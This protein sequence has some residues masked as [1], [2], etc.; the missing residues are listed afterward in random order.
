MSDPRTAMK[1]PHFVDPRKMANQGAHLQGDIPFA[2]LPRLA[3]AVLKA[4]EMQ[5]EVA[6]NRDEEQRT[7]VEGKYSLAVTMTCQRCLQPVVETIGGDIR[8]GVVWDENRAAE[9]P[10]WLDPWLLE[11][12]TGDLYR[13]LEDEFLLAL[14]IIP[15]HDESEC[16][17][18]GSYST[19]EVVEKRENPFDVLAKLKK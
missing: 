11:D 16:N 4:G 8:V 19:G 2:E 17:A 9:L 7:V 13:M 18:S 10:K 5:V 3:K 1:L 12:D 14:P 15:A 6:F